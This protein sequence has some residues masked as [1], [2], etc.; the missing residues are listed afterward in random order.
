[1]ARAGAGKGDSRARCGALQTTALGPVSVGYTFAPMPLSSLRPLLRL[2]AAAAAILLL[3]DVALF[4]SG[5]YYRWLEPDSTSG[6]VVG[7][8]LAIERYRD[9]KRRNVLVLGDSRIG[10]GFSAQLADD[11]GGRADLHFVNGAVAG[12][13]ARVRNLLLRTVDPDADRFGAIALAVDYDPGSVL[14]DMPNYPLD[15]SYVVPVL[16][17]GDIISYPDSFTD[18]AQRARA[19]RAILFPLQ[20]LHDDALDFLLHPRRR[21]D[22]ILRSRPGWLDA[23]GLYM[24]HEEALPELALDEHDVPRDWGAIEPAR[25]QKIEDYLRNAR[26]RATPALEAAN[27]DYVRRWIGGVAA[28]YRAHGVPVFVF[29]VPRGPWHQALVPAPTPRGAIAELADTG[30]IIALPGDA[31]VALEQPHFF[32]DTLHMNR[33]GRERFSADLAQRIAALVP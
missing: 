17:L 7:D 32:F 20:A 14:A 23:V 22:A 29:V 12:S 15:T 11:A 5:W 6:S 21:A 2:C 24:G 28:R 10:E 26:S 30:Q 19:R 1:M 3:L 9:P 8:I 4:R 27:E 13:T 33:A 25:R 16:H 18:P 31:F